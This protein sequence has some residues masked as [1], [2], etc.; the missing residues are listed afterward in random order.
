MASGLRRRSRSRCCW[1]RRHRAF[2]SSSTWKPGRPSPWPRAVASAP[3]PCSSAGA[4]WSLVP[5]LIPNLPSMVATVIGLIYIANDLEIS[6]STS[7]DES[8]SLTTPLTGSIKRT[9]TKAT[10]APKDVENQKLKSG[11]KASYE[12]VAQGPSE[13][14]SVNYLQLDA[15]THTST[16]VPTTPPTNHRHRRRPPPSYERMRRARTS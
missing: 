11:S 12:A 16:T 10:M 5:I 4:C 7:T 15:T 2:P 9:T 3:P 14:S 6:R 8:S 1:R 13:G